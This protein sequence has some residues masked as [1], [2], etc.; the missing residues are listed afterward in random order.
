MANYTAIFNWMNGLGFPVA[1]SQYTNFI[2]NSNDSSSETKFYS[3]ASL[4]IFDN[5]GNPLKVA[6][7]VDVFP[8]SL[9]SLVFTSTSQDVQYLVGSATFRYTYY[10]LE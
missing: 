8:T 2:N 5:T 3:D 1:Y 10:T 9:Q 6:K 4:Q 7:F